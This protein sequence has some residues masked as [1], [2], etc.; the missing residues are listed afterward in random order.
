MADNVTLP[1]TG[2]VVHTD[3]VVRNATTAQM[4]ISK[5]AL[6]D[7]GAFEGFVS[8]NNPMPVT[9]SML[10]HIAEY[11]QAVYRLLSYLTAPG[12]YDR[13]ANQ[14]RTAAVISSGTVTTVTSVTNEVS[15]GGIQGQVQVYG[16]NN[17]AWALMVRSRIS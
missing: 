13:A 6:G 11:A 4:E 12:W 16:A 2:A 14:L 8:A 5:I 7:E 17:A 10:D 9:A 15:I 1:G 3:E